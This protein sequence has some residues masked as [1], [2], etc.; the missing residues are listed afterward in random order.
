M[1]I[2]KSQLRRIIKEE[3]EAVL[4]E[5][6][7]PEEIVDA[8]YKQCDKAIDYKKCIEDLPP[9]TPQSTTRR[10]D[11]SGGKRFYDNNPGNKWDDDPRDAWYEE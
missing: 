5:E 11:N 3:L 10:R 1:K 6:M 2:T 4:G 7:S 9:R 8:Q